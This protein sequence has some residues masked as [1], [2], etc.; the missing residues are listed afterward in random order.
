MKEQ[1]IVLDEV[2][3]DER[4]DQIILLKKIR[5]LLSQ[6]KEKR[7]RVVVLICDEPRQILEVKK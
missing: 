2:W 5:L 6:I 3:I 1:M 7:E 4:D